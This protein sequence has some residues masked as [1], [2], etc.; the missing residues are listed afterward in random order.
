MKNGTSHHVS[1]GMKITKQR[2]DLLAKVMNSSYGVFGPEE[3]KDEH[4]TT[5]GTRVRILLP[6]NYQQF[7]SLSKIKLENPV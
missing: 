4:G 1:N 5:I 3:R 7:R 2:I 6:F